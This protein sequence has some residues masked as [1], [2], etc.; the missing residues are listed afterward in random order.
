MR[1]RANTPRTWHPKHPAAPRAFRARAR[2]R[3][4]REAPPSLSRRP[5]Q[6]FKRRGGGGPAPARLAAVEAGAGPAG[7]GRWLRLFPPA[8][9]QLPPPARRCSGDAPEPHPGHGPRPA[10]ELASVRAA[11]DLASAAA[12]G[13]TVHR[14]LPGTPGAQPG[15]RALLSSGDPRVT[16]REPPHARWSPRRGSGWSLPCLPEPRSARAWH[17][18]SRSG[19]AGTA[20]WLPWGPPSS[21]SLL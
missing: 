5:V 17:W 21:F 11:A 3:L 14:T 8:R 9:A 1:E 12:M 13:N 4:G 19:R 7:P 6:T 15:R 10:A 16:P 20:S 18:A 2:E